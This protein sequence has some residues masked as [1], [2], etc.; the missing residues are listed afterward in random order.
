MSPHDRFRL[1]RGAA[2]LHALGPRAVA[3]FIAEIANDQACT[4]AILH[5]LDEWRAR[6]TPEMLH[7]TGG[8]RFARCLHEVT[9]A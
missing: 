4:H 1:E 7:V 3:E 8:D 6:L 5:R 2:H 9:A